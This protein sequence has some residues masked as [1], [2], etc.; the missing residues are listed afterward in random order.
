MF[1]LDVGNHTSVLAVVEGAGADTVPNG[2]GSRATPSCLAFSAQQRCFGE[3]AAAQRTT[4]ARNTIEGLSSL[5]G[6]R[7]PDSAAGG[8]AAERCQTEL[9][10]DGVKVSYGGGDVTLATEA[11]VGAFMGGMVQLARD[12]HPVQGQEPAIV[13]AVPSYYTAVQRHALAHAGAIASASVF[14]LCDETVATA[15]FYAHER[16]HGG[17]QAEQQ[18]VLFVDAGHCHT[19]AFVVHYDLAANALRVVDSETVLVGGRDFDA[20]LAQKFE[21]DIQEQKGVEITTARA[22]LRL[23][24]EAEKAKKVLSANSSWSTLMEELQDGL[25]FA[26]KATR[27]EFAELCDSASLL[28]RLGEGVTALLLRVLTSGAMHGVPIAAAE[29]FGGC[30]R[31]PAVAAAMMTALRAIEGLAGLPEGRSLNGAESVSRGCS[32]YGVSM[33]AGGQGR[34]MRVQHCTS[35]PMS[36][37]LDVLSD[38]TNQ[39]AAAVVAPPVEEA[40]P[41]AGDDPMDTA[42]EGDADCSMFADDS[43]LLDLPSVPKTDPDAPGGGGIVLGVS[44]AQPLPYVFGR[45]AGQE[46]SVDPATCAQGFARVVLSIEE[47]SDCARPNAD[48]SSSAVTVMMYALEL[49][50]SGEAAMQS[51]ESSSWPLQ[52]ALVSNDGTLSVLQPASRGGEPLLRLSP[53][54]PTALSTVQQQP[55]LSAQQL[56]T[57]VEQERTMRSADLQV[58]NA[59][60]E[61]NRLET[62]VYR[63][64]DT[65]RQC[66]T[67]QE[68]QETLPELERTEDWLYDGG[69]AVDNP[70]EGVTSADL[71]TMYEAKTGAIEQMCSSSVNRARLWSDRREVLRQLLD[72][73][74]ILRTVAVDP[75]AAARFRLSTKQTVAVGKSVSEAEKWLSDR[76]M[77]RTQWDAALGSEPPNPAAAVE[78]AANPEIVR[79]LQKLRADL[80]AQWP[81]VMEGERAAGI[82]TSTE[83]LSA[84][85]G[86][87]KGT[88]IEVEGHGEGV[89]ESFESKWIGAN[90][91]T[92]NFQNDG[93]VVSTRKVLKL[94]DLRWKVVAPASTD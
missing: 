77:P 85:K 61:H 79:M 34:L 14:Q 65:V 22:K 5:L 72:V 90:E 42:Q 26:G 81:A 28:A 33:E 32:L 1:G 39:A 58:A 82:A 48:G 87:M 17:D 15:L 70:G 7:A 49:T 40:Q 55:L 31:V 41:E 6:R 88:R 21:R 10:G 56:Q 43:R 84:D 60:E 94:R 64:R 46:L 2:I 52:I 37:S 8:P 76:G 89:Y 78:A 83:Q 16:L 66:G 92:L 69:S 67:E 3:D 36:L 93:H 62:L 68:I 25:D 23:L 91:H 86:L 19:T 20:L 38:G 71:I 45:E 35:R 29:L 80:E 12:V 57:L 59:I 18:A 9:G 13:L 54:A 51:A 47:E 24:A 30:T 4:N 73:L 53:L 11:V 63:L 50:N 27:G 75:T 74:E 44:R